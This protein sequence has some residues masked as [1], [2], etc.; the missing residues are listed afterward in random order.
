MFAIEFFKWY[1]D[2]MWE[3]LT[4]VK[5]LRRFL[6]SNRAAEGQSLPPTTGSLQLHIRRAHYIVMIWRRATE[7]H[8]SLPSPA[9]CG[10]ELL[11]EEG[12]YTPIQ[13]C[14]SP[15]PEA[16]I[17]LVKCGCKKGCTRWCSCIKNNIPCTEVCGCVGY[18][19]NNRHNPVEHLVAEEDEDDDMWL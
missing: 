12:I 3:V 15:A 5:D 19:C 16:V 11:A 1:D 2:V 4:E 18:S 10:W 8:P 6:F 7:S 9:A 17:N 13:M 14:Q